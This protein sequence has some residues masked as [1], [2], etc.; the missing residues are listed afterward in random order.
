MFRGKSKGRNS[1]WVYGWYAPI[2]ISDSHGLQMAIVTD[3][4][5]DY[6]Y[7]GYG[8]CIASP[9]FYMVDPKTVGQYTGL[10]DKNGK[11]IFEGD[12]V[13]GVDRMYEDLQLHGYVGYENGSFVIVGDIIT[14]YRWIDYEVEVIG[15]IHD[16]PELLEE[17]ER[18]SKR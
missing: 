6:M 1:E 4:P 2:S 7:M 18:C 17:E 10:L 13:K 16:N 11:K 5:N 8:G 9:K 14:H 3:E 15:N 12:I